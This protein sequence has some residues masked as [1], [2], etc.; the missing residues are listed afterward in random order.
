MADD[1][2][3]ARYGRVRGAGPATCPPRCEPHGSGSWDR[4]RSDDIPFDVLGRGRL[5][6]AVSPLLPSPCSARRRLALGRASDDRM[7]AYGD[8]E[9]VRVRDLGPDPGAGW[10]AA[11]PVEGPR[12]APHRR[13]RHHSLYAL[14][15]GSPDPPPAGADR[16]KGSRRAP[17]RGRRPT[18]PWRC[19][20][21]RPRRGSQDVASPSPVKLAV[22]F[23]NRRHFA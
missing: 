20:V 6:A 23:A 13:W 14:P 18:L 10:K 19:R 12:R 21:P 11:A 1:P 17:L 15:R 9:D 22:P 5:G 2:R 8:R 16:A 4:K 7:G 3:G